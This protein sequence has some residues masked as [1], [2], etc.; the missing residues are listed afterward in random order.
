M[1]ISKVIQC[2]AHEVGT[3]GSRN[4]PRP[5]C[6]KCSAVAKDDRYYVQLYNPND[7][8]R[9]KKVINGKRNAEQ[10]E[11]EM[12]VQLA[13]GATAKAA[14]RNVTVQQFMEALM[15]A[16]PNLAANTRRTYGNHLR[17]HI[18]PALGRRKVTSLTSAMQLTSFFE[19]V[20]RDHGKAVRRSV[21][22][23]VRM[24]IKAA[25]REGVLARNCLDGIPFPKA[26][27]VRGVPFAPSMAEIMQVREQWVTARQGV[28][29]GEGVMKVAMLDV[30]AG[31]GIRVG[32][33]CGLALKDVDFDNRT[34][35]VTRQVIY[36][37]GNGFTFADTKTDDSGHRVIPAPDFVLDA[38]LRSQ[39]RSGTR[40]ITLPWEEPDGSR[41]VMERELVFHSLRTDGPFRPQTFQNLLNTTGQVVGLPG[42]LHPHSLRH[43]YT[44]ELHDGGVPQI[45]IDYVTG[46]LPT[47]SV[48]MRLY[49]QPMQ[50]GLA[51]ARD[52]IQAA[53]DGAQP[54]GD[55]RRLRRAI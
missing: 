10:H 50:T 21:E 54:E 47:G 13:G 27:R 15:E 20:Q 17:L 12:K 16:K 51:K 23:L 37:P 34:I 52:V 18:Y 46:H 53:W 38:I 36:H 41:G 55:R 1:A 32:E 6:A 19:T 11:A 40:L 26:T 25:V 31:T 29:P 30:L 22:S 9:Y 3:A 33:L 24:L 7:S 4:K 8:S 42:S 45:C 39:R 44:T 48:T 43:R 14:D 35:S 28:A 49:T 2:Q 5:G